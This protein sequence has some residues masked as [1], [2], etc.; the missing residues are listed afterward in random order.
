M[1]VTVRT[2]TVDEVLARIDEAARREPGG[3]VA[4]DGDG[5]LWSGDIGEDFF[6]AVLASGDLSDR[7]H[8]ALVREA[9]AEGIDTSGSAVDLARRIFGAYLA[10]QFSE[11]RVCEICAWACAGWSR[12]RVDAF[13]VELLE[14]VELR[15]RLH[16]EAVRV[17]RHCKSASID[18]HIVSASP[19]PVVH[20]AARILDVALDRVSAVVEQCDAN[21]VILPAVH[22]PIPYGPGKV[23]CLREKLGA[24]VLYAAFG[25]NAFDVPLLAASKIPVMIRPKS[26][27]TERAAEIPE[28]VI[29]R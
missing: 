12:A 10:G 15:S 17:L 13:A 20:A 29:L 16:E 1:L 3:A 28:A 14:R 18:V 24:R 26:R 9:L 11:E 2:Q 22:R 21:D 19:R 5:T 6:S 8:E 27:L 7:A 23:T 25:D 4:F